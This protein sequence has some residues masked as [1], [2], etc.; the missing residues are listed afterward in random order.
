L[1]EPCGTTGSWRAGCG[2]SPAGGTRI[3]GPGHA[4]AGAARQRVG[5]AFALSHIS[6][7]TDS[8]ADHAAARRLELLYNRSFTDPILAGRYPDGE[9]ELWDG[10]SDFRFRVDGDINVACAGTVPSTSAVTASSVAD[11]R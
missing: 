1:P 11:P 4:G 7:A 8:P 9:A 2:T 3:G 6:P 5:I 10:V